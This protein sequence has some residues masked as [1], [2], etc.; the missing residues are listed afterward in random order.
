[1][2]CLFEKIKSQLDL[3][4]RVTFSGG[5]PLQQARGLARIAET[6][7][8]FGTHTAVETSGIVPVED[9]ELVRPYVDTWLVGMRVLVD[10][11]TRRIREFERRMH[12][13][14]TCLRNSNAD[15]IIARIA[16][17]P[18]Y[19]TQPVYLESVK[20]LLRTYNVTKLEVLMQ[21]PETAHFYAAMGAAPRVHFENSVAVKYH[22]FV[23]DYFS[24]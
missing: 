10:L 15:E 23:K 18:E 5:E 20:N 19:T 7:K 1:V 21:N 8:L 24:Q 3:L 17:I 13:T 6:C 11:D 12:N 14:L 2:D 4:K 22:Q 9:I 16:V